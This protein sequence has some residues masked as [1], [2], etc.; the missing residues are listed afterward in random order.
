MRGPPHV[1]PPHAARPPGNPEIPGFSGPGAYCVSK[2]LW[3]NRGHAAQKEARDPARSRALVRTRWPPRSLHRGSQTPETTSGA[4]SHGTQSAARAQSTS[5]D[6]SPEAPPSIPARP[7]KPPPPRIELI[8]DDLK[9]GDQCVVWKYILVGGRWT[10]IPYQPARPREKAKADVPST[11]SSF[12]V[13]WSVYLQGGFDGIGFEF[14]EDDPYFGVDLDRCLRDGQLK[15]WAIPLAEL[16][17]LSYHEISPSGEGLKF[18]ARGQLPERTGTRRAGMGPDG[19]GALKVYDHGRFFTITG[20][21]YGEPRPI[22]D[23]PEAAV[24]LYREAKD[25]GKARA[26]GKSE[27]GPQ[28][29]PTVPTVGSVIGLALV[30]V[31][32]VTAADLRRLDQ[33]RASR[34]GEAFALLYDEGRWFD[35]ETDLNVLDIRL[36]NKLVYWFDADAEAMERVFWHSKLGERLKWRERQDYRTLTVR[37]AID[38]EQGTRNGTTY[39][40]PVAEPAP[41][42]QATVPPIAPPPTIPA[43]AKDLRKWFS[44]SRQA[45]GD[46]EKSVR[47]A[48][49]MP[50]LLGDLEAVGEGWPKRVQDRLFIGG[51]DFKPV[52]LETP[53]ILFG[54]LDGKASVHWSEGVMMITQARFFEHLRQ[55]APTVE[56]FDAIETLPHHP[57]MPGTY[58]LHRRFEVRRSTRYLDEFIGFFTPAT[59]VDRSLL[60]AAILTPFWGGPPGQR[61]AFR[62]RGPDDDPPELAGRGTGKTTQVEVLADLAGGLVDL[63]EGEDINALKTRLLSKEGD[64]RVLRIDNLKTLKLSWAALEKFISSKVISGKRLYHGE[65]Q[66]P[67]TITVFITINAGTFSKDMAQRIVEIQLSRPVYTDNWLSDVN[68]FLDEHRWDLIGEIIG[69]LDHQPVGVVARS[70]WPMWRSKSSPSAAASRRARTRSPA[71]SRPWT[72]T[73][74]TPTSSRSSTRPRSCCGRRTPTRSGSRS[75]PASTPNGSRSMRRSRSPRTRRPSPWASSRSSGSGITG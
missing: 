73:T 38:H 45:K 55:F 3:E 19:D 69:T 37:D 66:R 14:S 48:L 75:R 1:T 51:R 57:P 49:T 7:S 25:R 22:I 44:N 60:R 62:L 71:A 9:S 64:K 27:A 18:I 59:E 39:R 10:K 68:K 63:E 32:P 52:Y 58:Y 67:N 4:D 47:K 65:G 74:P 33:A 36:M 50:Q 11:W 23:L 31:P 12:D 56:V 20:D 54:W 43:T 53:T 30:D 6:A 24:T 61:P 5:V 70:R 26:N 72:T 29:V 17:S 40:P 46:D 42:G 2:F 28:S 16:V 8:P 13:A 21:V 35:G 34:D 41:D 15:P